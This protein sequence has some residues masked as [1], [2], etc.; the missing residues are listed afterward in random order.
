MDLG[1]NSIPI[2]FRM[3]CWDRLPR[4]C[5]VSLS[6]QCCLNLKICLCILS[7]AFLEIRE[8][9]VQSCYVLSGTKP[10]ISEVGLRSRK[11]FACCA[12]SGDERCWGAAA[13]GLTSVSEEPA[14]KCT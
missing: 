10:L 6:T 13:P 5:G 4:D 1:N 11:C 3:N 9:S 2:N 14:S 7:L 8:V 12:S